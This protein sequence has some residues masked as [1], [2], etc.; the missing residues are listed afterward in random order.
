MVKEQILKISREMEP[1]LIRIRH[2]LHRHPELSLKETFTATL[3]ADTMRKL[4]GVRLQENMAEG[5]GVTGV[6][7]GGKGPGRCVLLR[8]DIDALPIQEQVD[9]PFCSEVPGCMH[10][11]GHDAHTTWLLGAAMILSRLRNEFSGTV[12]FVFQPGEEIGGGACSLIQ[13]DRVLEDPPV[14]AAFAAHAWPELPLGQIGIASRIP[15]G[16]AGGFE[17][18][19][20]GKGGH[21]S[22]PYRCRNPISIAAEIC[23]RFQAIVAERIDSAEPRVIS[24]GSIHAGDRSN[25]IPETCCMSGTIRASDPAVMEQLGREIEHTVRSITSMHGA[26]YK[27]TLRTS[28][29]PV[30]NDS[31]MVRLVSSAARD[32]LGQANCLI[33]DK[34]YLGG[35]NFAE[36]SSRVPSCYFFA[37]IATEETAGKFGLHSP[38]FELPDTVIAPVA[39]VFARIALLALETESG[40]EADLSQSMTSLC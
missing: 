9:I 15:F 2:T 10:A 6:L 37:G 31:A 39:A 40:T 12:K 25:I 34:R 24:V 36:F 26:S 28:G 5:T 1:E 35:E 18:T 29:K 7:Y 20:L 13:K 38:N 30:E 22:W 3:I 27:L 8:A 33:L 21:G 19:I 17:L 11:C 16:C 23:T 4:E 32:I 14:D